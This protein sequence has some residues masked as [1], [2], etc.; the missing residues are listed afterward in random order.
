MKNIAG[1]CQAVGVQNAQRAALAIQLIIKKQDNR[2][3]FH[4]IKIR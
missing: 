3:N 1:I 2:V 4:Q